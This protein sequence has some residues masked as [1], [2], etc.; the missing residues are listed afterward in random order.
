MTKRYGYDSEG[1]LESFTLTLPDR[2]R[3]PFTLDYRYDTAGRLRHLSY[4]AGYGL[5][6]APRKQLDL[7]YDPAGRIQ[8]LTVN[9]VRHATDISYSAQGWPT[10]LTT[11]ADGPRPVTELNEPAT[12]PG[13]LR[14]QQVLSDGET[15]LDLTYQ[16]TRPG[17]SGITGQ[18]TSATDSLHPER[19]T[20]YTYDALARLSQA[21]A[22]HPDERRQWTQRYTYDRFGNRT[23]VAAT[24]TTPDG[25]PIPLDG[26]PALEYGRPRSD[27]LRRS[28]N[29]ITTP[30]FGYD[31]AGNLL[32]GLAADGTWQ[33]YRYDDAGRLVAVT[34]DTGTLQESYTYGAC[35]QRIRTR[36]ATAG[37]DLCHVWDDDR[38]I[39]EYHVDT[40]AT[41]WVRSSVYLGDRLLC[42]YTAAE[43]S[44]RPSEEPPEV[45]RYYHPDRLGTRL[46]TTPDTKEVAERIT[47]P[48][49]TLLSYQPRPDEAPVF[50]S[51]QR[52][53]ATG[54]DYAVN[55]H[56]APHLGR[57]LQTDPL[58]V[59]AIRAGEP[60]SNNAYAYC[61]ADPV[62]STDPIGLDVC[63]EGYCFP[64]GTLIA[65]PIVVEGRF[66]PGQATVPTR[67]RKRTSA[68][69]A[70]NAAS[71]DDH[72]RTLRSTSAWARSCT[73]RW[74]VNVLPKVPSGT[75]AGRPRGR[76]SRN[77]GRNCSRP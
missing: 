21:R 47:L 12:L 58:S 29:R 7:T 45:L 76:P 75:D 17:L 11:G 55:R 53:P 37:T 33:R 24:G 62:N 8:G 69:S 32:R 74:R 30:G 10:T 65:D 54:L 67:A 34:D 23:G 68:P 36:D 19:S 57:F 5:P 59:D 13:L 1:R 9:G 18:L 16:Y 40:P 63:I 41:P 43:R 60:Q 52:S 4:P 38:V 22:G 73:K 49:G 20:H 70:E 48:Y 66:P 46:I 44:K 15:L 28:D 6:G 3:R 2:P 39:A 61:L 42:T 31:E 35:R 51:Y 50:T 77:S 27:G 26:L 64:D 72:P 14:R 56:Y 71:A 25:N